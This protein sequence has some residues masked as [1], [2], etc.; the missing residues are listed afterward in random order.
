MTEDRGRALE[1]IPTWSARL[2][3]FKSRSQRGEGKMRERKKSRG[4]HDSCYVLMMRVA[5][6]L[7]SPRPRQTKFFS[8]LFAI[9]SHRPLF[10]VSALL[11]AGPCFF[12]LD[13]MSLLWRLP[14]YN[15]LYMEYWF[16]IMQH[17]VRVTYER[18]DYK[19]IFFRF[20]LYEPWHSRQIT[21][22]IIR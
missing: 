17:C 2:V 15:T 12:L 3:P 22:C 16:F 1:L 18:I 8:F 21:C 9:A 11:R 5:S 6:N 14:I 4:R 13:S 7:K 19:E 10:I 20:V